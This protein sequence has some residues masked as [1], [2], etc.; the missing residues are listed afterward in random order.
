MQGEVLEDGIDF[1]MQELSGQ[2]ALT[3]PQDG[4]AVAD[5]S[6][7]GIKVPFFLSES[8]L[9]SV[10]TVAREMDAT[11]YVV[12]LAAYKVLLTRYSNATDIAVLL[13]S[14]H[15]PHRSA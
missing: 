7:E 8:L 3:L 2:R 13:R 5:G 4:E 12:L 9:K 14:Y 1:W 15:V 10:K 6:F 11:L